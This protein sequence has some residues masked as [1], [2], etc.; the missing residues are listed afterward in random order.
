[1]K[2]NVYR[3]VFCSMLGVAVLSLNAT[4]SQA[5]VVINEVHYNPANDISG[6]A[7]GD[8]IRSSSQDEFVEIVNGNSF[9]VDI[10]GWTLADDDGVCFTVPQNT[11]LNSLQAM[12]VFGG[13][14]PTGDFGNSQVYTK[15]LGLN[16]ANNIVVLSD[17]KGIKVD[18]ISYKT[19]EG[20][21][22]SLT[23]NPDILGELVPFTSIGDGSKLF[24][25]GK[26]IT[27]ISFSEKVTNET[28]D[29]EKIDLKVY[30]NPVTDEIYIRFN[31]LITA[32]SLMDS[33]GNLID[34]NLIGNKISLPE[35]VKAGLFNLKVQTSDR[36]YVKKM[37]VIR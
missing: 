11:M 12:L 26:T 28:E 22:K 24:S 17:D 27:A 6:D 14:Q 18:S 5:Q 21:G 36:F 10:S 19:S 20:I 1:M 34:L 23:R 37:V 25:P 7:N 8:G 15:N 16:N 33:F 35:S 4:K 2:K 31:E 32:V 9:E 3:A 13:G 29:L 30:P